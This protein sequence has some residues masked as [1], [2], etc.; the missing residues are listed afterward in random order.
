MSDKMDVEFAGDGRVSTKEYVVILF[1]A[2]SSLAKAPSQI[3]RKSLA[4][5]SAYL[6]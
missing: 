4:N 1:S 2:T 6:F 3:V 5:G